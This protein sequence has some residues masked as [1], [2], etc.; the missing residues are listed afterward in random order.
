MVYWY[1]KKLPTWLGYSSLQSADSCYLTPSCSPNRTRF[2][3]HCHLKPCTGTRFLSHSHL[4]PFTGLDGGDGI[5]GYLTSHEA[6]C[7]CIGNHSGDMKMKGQPN[8]DSNPVPP[9]QG[10]NHATNWANETGSDQSDVSFEQHPTWMKLKGDCVLKPRF[11]SHKEEQAYYK[12]LETV[13]MTDW[14]QNC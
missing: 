2:L 3:S 4:H 1:M 8:R 5:F 7:L 13:A 10:S 6:C 14:L 12:F 11:K 9:S